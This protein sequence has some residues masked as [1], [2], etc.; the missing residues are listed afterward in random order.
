VTRPLVLG[1]AGG[2]G[3]GKTTLVELLVARAGARVAHLPHDAYYKDLADMPDAVRAATNWDHPDALDNDLFLRHV[4]ELTAGRGIDRPVYDFTVH[5]RAA[6]A[7]RV[8]PRP[9]VLLEGILLFAV[10]AIRDA[11]DVR[12][13]VDTPA[14]LRLLRRA[15]RD[16][17]ERDRSIESVMDQYLSTVRPMHD[18]FVE[19]GRLHAHLV[20][21]WEE[22]NE[23]AGELLAR[24]VG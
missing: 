6:D 18:R 16:V 4:A 21:P 2:S 23:T 8:E 19:P 17:T 3:S 7:V 24:F 1:V 15:R 10:P 14:D 22:R 11:I 13:F 5:A 12:V 9:V 20:V